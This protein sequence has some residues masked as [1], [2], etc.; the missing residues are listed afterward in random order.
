M[1]SRLGKNLNLPSEQILEIGKQAT[2][3]E[4]SAARSPVNKKIDVAVRS[5]L[6]ARDGAE[7]AHVPRPM[8]RGYAEDL[9]S[10][11]CKQFL[12]AHIQ[13]FG[14]AAGI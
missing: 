3:K 14:R 6:A 1:K 5:G 4:R 7:H 10:F 9:R 11:G 12:D 13:S 2:G 8:E